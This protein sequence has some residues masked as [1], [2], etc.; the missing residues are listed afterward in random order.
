MNDFYILQIACLVVL[1]KLIMMNSDPDI[2]YAS[3]VC[4]CSTRVLS[5]C[6]PRPITSQNIKFSEEDYKSEQ[7]VAY[8]YK[9]IQMSYRH[10]F[11]KPR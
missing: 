2:N 11:S 3:I 10:L 9:H 1:P 7:K 6:R 5:A 4:F 8:I